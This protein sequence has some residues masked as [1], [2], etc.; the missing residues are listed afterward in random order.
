M[1]F[2]DDGSSS[3]EADVEFA[4]RMDAERAMSKNHCSMGETS[5][6]KVKKNSVFPNLKA[7][8]KES[9]RDL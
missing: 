9:M 8:Q 7:S 1:R 2:N 6:V 4:T 3:E 5:F